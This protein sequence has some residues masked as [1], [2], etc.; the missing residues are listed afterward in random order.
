MLQIFPAFLRICTELW[1]FLKK[2]LHILE[3]R[4]LHTFFSLFLTTYCELNFAL[5]FYS[6]P[7]YLS[8]SGVDKKE[9]VWVVFIK[10]VSDH[11]IW[12][13][14]LLTKKNIFFGVLISYPLNPWHPQTWQQKFAFAKI[15][16]RL[17]FKFTKN[18]YLDFNFLL[19]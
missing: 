14:I 13:F 7:I 2:S 5:I 15:Y 1:T 17:P 16:W 18:I 9:R 4:K 19:N 6:R 11:C 10:K 3:I 8:S 12:I